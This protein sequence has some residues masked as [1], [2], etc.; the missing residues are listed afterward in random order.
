MR[1]WAVFTIY[2]LLATAAG[3][4][5]RVT[6]QQLERILA[7]RSGSPV[8]A[9]SASDSDLMDQIAREGSLSIELKQLQLTERLTERTRARF[10]SKYDL[11]P[12]TQDALELLADRSALLDP[13]AAEMPQLP[14]PD[15]EA[16]Q[17]ILH[18]AEGY[19]FNTLSRLPN[20]FALRSTTQFD[21]AP[22]EF[23]GML[24]DPQPGIHRVD[25][26]QSEI[27]YRGGREVLTTIQGQEQPQLWTVGLVSQG[28]F[29]PEAA[30]V[31]TDLAHGTARF[32]HWEQN[33]AGTVAVF[34]Y[35][36]PTSA[37]HYNISYSC[38]VSHEFHR[39]PA[40]SGSLAIEP[41]NGTLTRFTLIADP[42]KGDPISHV[43]SVVE[44]GSEVLGNKHYILPLK[45]LTFSVQQEDVCGKGRHPRRL[46]RP[47]QMLN[48]IQFTQYHRL[49]SESTI[50]L[51]KP[52]LEGS[53]TKAI[54]GS[55]G[56]QI[57]APPHRATDAQTEP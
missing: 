39:R 36:I 21:D 28:E 8:D 49:G 19:L 55:A 46:E 30:T 29:G 27:T 15:P 18:A 7:E 38:H 51:S 9:S 2:I 41:A 11:G 32:D 35:R 13:P 33:E 16:E 54:A 24:V 48:R 31:F 45:S 37:S 6:V 4:S 20:F 14:A 12:M 57:S 25:T 34:K 42:E 26:S 44:Y 22:I 10:V 50:V 40:Y 47:I 5:E 43:A 56:P 53:E 1:H 3:A 23:N 17:S 52:T